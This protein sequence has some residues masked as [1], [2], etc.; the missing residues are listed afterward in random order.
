MLIGL[1]LLQKLFKYLEMDLEM[2]E[3]KTLTLKDFISIDTN[4]DGIY[5][6]FYWKKLTTFGRA[7]EGLRKKLAR[8][9]KGASI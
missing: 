3:K 9:I 6:N 8:P 2:K 7:A 1:Q 4:Q 5:H